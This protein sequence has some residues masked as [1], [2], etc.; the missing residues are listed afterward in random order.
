MVYEIG[1]VHKTNSAHVERILLTSLTFNQFPP[2][3]RTNTERI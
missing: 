3:H 2:G 1:G